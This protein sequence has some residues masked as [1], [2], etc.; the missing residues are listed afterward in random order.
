MPLLQNSTRGLVR[1]ALAAGVDLS[2]NPAKC[3][4]LP[5]R[6]SRGTDVTLIRIDARFA[7]K[8]LELHGNCCR[9]QDDATAFHA[10]LAIHQ[11]PIHHH[12]LRIRGQIAGVKLAHVDENAKRF[13]CADQCPSRFILP[14]IHLCQIDFSAEDELIAIALLGNVMHFRPSKNI[15]RR[16]RRMHEG[17]DGT[18]VR[19]SGL[20]PPKAARRQAGP[21]LPIAPQ[22]PC[23]VSRSALR[24]GAPSFP[25]SRWV[26]PRSA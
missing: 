17:C 23:A 15:Y 14:A 21:A 22:S 13:W 18:G 26:R 10:G 6:V 1:H 24:S 20:T 4:G 12:R 2:F 5:V 25:L 11:L 3:P 19:Y 8:P 7:S 16:E 9:L